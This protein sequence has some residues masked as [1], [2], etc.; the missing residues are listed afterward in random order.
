MINLPNLYSIIVKPT[1]HKMP[2]LRKVLT[3]SVVLFVCWLSPIGAQQIAITID[4][5]PS[6]FSQQYRPEIRDQLLI[7]QLK[8]ANVDQVVFFVTGKFADSPQALRRLQRYVEAGHLIAN[9][10][11]HHWDLRKKEATSYAQDILKAESVIKHLPNF[12]KWYRF[13]FLREGNT[14]EKR[15]QLRQF[16]KDHGYINGYVTIDNWDFYI[17][18]LLRDG[19]KQGRRF[20]KANLQKVYLEH[21]WNAVTF[22]EG[23]AKAFIDHPV[24]H[25]LLLHDNDL[26]AMFIKPLVELLRDKGWTIIS[27][28]A[29]Y[30]DKIVKTE[31]DVLLNNQGRVVAIAK[32]QGYPGPYKTN[33]NAKAIEAM[34]KKHKVWLD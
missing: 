18:R 4:D 33:E 13:P 8:A 5:A 23:I 27:P 21:I 14:R 28:E 22:Y 32:S 25:T 3:T 34:F 11:Y 26:T 20:N 2:I 31:P 16:L 24:K 6:L 12:K 10:S 7:Q 29:A 30:T 19:L 9:H 17:D 1:T 15:D